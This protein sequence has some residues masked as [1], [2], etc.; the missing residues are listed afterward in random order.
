MSLLN[1]EKQFHLHTGPEDIGNYVIMPGDP[2]RVEIIADYLDDA[3]FVASN[4]EYTTYTG[5]LCGE[6]VSVI[7]TGIG[8]PSAAIA[9]EELVKCGAHT[10]IRVGTSGGMDLSVSGGDLVVVS[11]AV[12]AEGTSHEYLP[13]GYPA[14]AHY[15]VVRSLAEAA[16]QLSE[17]TDGKRFHVGVVQSKDSF[18]GE[19]NPETMPVQ[20]MLREKWEGYLRCGCLASEMECAAIFSAALARGIRAGAVLTAIWNVE[21]SNAGLPDRV[22]NNS[23]RAIRCAV[24]AVKR[25]IERDKRQ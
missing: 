2:G 11:A 16:E 17:D 8:G 5:F 6:K 7:S 12:R 14:V 21:R 3:M 13:D 19:T 25:L 4:R 24:D 23:D 22:F 15:E 10:L 9:V 20:A 18:Y 1:T